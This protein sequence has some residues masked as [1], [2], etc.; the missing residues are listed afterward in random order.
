MT[1]LAGISGQE[2]R[3]AFERDGWIFRRQRGSHMI[4]KK[5]N[6]RSLLSIPDHRELKIPLLKRFI[7]DAEITEDK[8]LEL[9]GR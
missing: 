9:L 5:E 8:F 6:V 3:K 4:L 1:R 7:R 2:A